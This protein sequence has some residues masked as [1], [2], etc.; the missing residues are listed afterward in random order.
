MHDWKRFFEE[1]AERATS[2]FEYDR[3]TSPR[4]TEIARLS[5]EELLRFVDPQPWEV[6][7]DA[8][9][10]TGANISLLHLR[11]K[12]IIGMDYCDGAIAR[13]ERRLV[14]DRIKNVRLMRGDVTAPP[15]SDNSVDKI[16]CTSVLQYLTDT[17][18]RKSF[19]EFAR[20]LRDQGILILHVKNLSSLYLST[21]WAVKKTKL[22]LRMKTKVQY[23]RSHGWYVMELQAFG[24]EIVAYNSFPFRLGLM[25]RHG[26]ELKFK[27]RLKKFPNSL[28]ASPVRR[29]SLSD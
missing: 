15:L 5:T 14:T 4:A 22:L 28:T 20:I 24:F 18:V 25:R 8:G 6:V 27:A 26:S 23:L 12:E 2:D 17:D 21:L 16:L 7:F 19:A 1:K 11:V 3:G 9:C 10:G 13:C 29:G